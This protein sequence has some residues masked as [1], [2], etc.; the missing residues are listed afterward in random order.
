MGN[1]LLPGP[2]KYV[3]TWLFGLF[4]EV[5]GCSFAYCRGPG[6]HRLVPDS[7]NVESIAMLTYA[8]GCRGGQVLGNL[9]QPWG[10]LGSIGDY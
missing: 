10:V 4:V 3:R 1:F 8:V 2:Q 9:R 6:T 5:L 7:F